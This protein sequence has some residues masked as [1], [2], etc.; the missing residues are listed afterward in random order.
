MNNKKEVAQV[1]S[2]ENPLTLLQEKSNR[3]LINKYLKGT[4][5]VSGTDVWA[6]DFKDLKA[7]NNDYYLKN[8]IGN[9]YLSKSGI[10]VALFLYSYFIQ[11][12][13]QLENLSEDGAMFTISSAKETGFEYENIGDGV[14]Y[15]AVSN[16]KDISYF[17]TPFQNLV[18]LLEEVG[19]ELDHIKILEA[20]QELH[21]F[22]YLTMTSINDVERSTQPSKRANWRHIRLCKW[23]IEKP[24]FTKI[25]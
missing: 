18:I 5:L 3:P 6:F 10:K 21:D 20:L 22:H 11:D 17:E 12:E 1:G 24:F 8:I 9:K 16:R 4:S 2:D 14:G 23:M 25:L 19:C 7:D 13:E 15:F